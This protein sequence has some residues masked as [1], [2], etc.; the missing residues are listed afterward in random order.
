MFDSL[1]PYNFVNVLVTEIAIY[2]N[3]HAAVTVTVELLKV[4]ALV[5]HTYSVY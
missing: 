1:V 2:N 5:S 3:T 4:S